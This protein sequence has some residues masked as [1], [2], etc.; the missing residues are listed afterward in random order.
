ML[1]YLIFIFMI[2]F[3]SCAEQPN[4]N[5]PGYTFPPLSLGKLVDL[6]KVS[7]S[8]EGFFMTTNLSDLYESGSERGL[9]LYVCVRFL[10]DENLN[11]KINKSAI[12]LLIQTS[13]DGE[14]SA[15]N[16]G[17]VAESILLLY[18]ENQNQF[19]YSERQRFQLKDSFI[20]LENVQYRIRNV[21]FNTHHKITSISFI[22]GDM[23]PED[24]KA[25]DTEDVEE[26]SDNNGNS[27]N[28]NE[29]EEEEE[30]IDSGGTNDEEEPEDRLMHVGSFARIHS[31][32]CSHWPIFNY[33]H[34]EELPEHLR[35]EY[36]EDMEGKPPKP[37]MPDLNLLPTNGAQTTE[38]GASKPE[39]SDP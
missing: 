15:D 30:D 11:K 1:K 22:P 6:K 7:E 20:T 25:K 21:E 38:D 18:S 29:Q 36:K 16:K 34:N 5:Q 32:S 13:T 27:D 4:E 28:N 24:L 26:N 33:E 17:Q 10:N 8:M 31:S 14:V 9:Y 2:F 3:M 12:P 23:E 39:S 37:G 19:L 35:V